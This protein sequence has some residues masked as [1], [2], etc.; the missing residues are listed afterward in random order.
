[1]PNV[2]PSVA[3]LGQAFAGCSA[4]PQRLPENHA[5]RDSKWTARHE[6]Y[7]VWSAIDDAKNKAGKLSDAAVAEFEKASD[8]AQAKA[9]AIELY[10][11]KYYAACTFGGYI[12][13]ST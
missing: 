10:S 1:M 12:Y 3:T 8:K 13:R 7:P 2:F 5:K 4:F 11:P 6:L 9:G